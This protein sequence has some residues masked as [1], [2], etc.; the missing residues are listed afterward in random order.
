MFDFLDLLLLR[1]G[2]PS[3]DRTLTFRRIDGSEQSPVIYFLPWHTPY[4]IARQAGFTPLDFLAAYEMPRAIVSSE[5]ELS[6]K[7]MLGLV[8]DAAKVLRD[9]GVAPAKATIV[10]LSVGT[11]P[12]TYL[13]NRIGA[14]LCAVAGA[15]RADLMFWQSPAAR[16]VRRRAV[17]KGFRFADYAKAMLGYHPAHNLSGIHRKSLFV[18]GSRD[19]FIPPR[20]KAG[21]LRAID[22]HAPSA[23]VVSLDAGHFRT[24]MVSSRYQREMLGIVPV[25]RSWQIRLPFQGSAQSA[26]PAPEPAA[27]PATLALPSPR[28]AS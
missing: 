21:L 20:R 13:A 4:T 7:A 17:Q 25:R 18:V 28:E 2:I 8:D 24:L 5:P 14:R 9:H 11:F 22:A 6:V 26:R 27:M 19:P 16:I 1:R 15:D 3:D 23:R 12:A 10:G